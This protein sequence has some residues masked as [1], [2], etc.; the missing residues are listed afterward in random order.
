MIGHLQSGAGQRPLTSL[1]AFSPRAPVDALLSRA[2]K[3]TR[4]HRRSMS[5]FSVVYPSPVSPAWR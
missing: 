1:Q 2:P 5:T 4:Q 3:A